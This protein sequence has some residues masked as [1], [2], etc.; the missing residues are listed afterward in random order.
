MEQK[1]EGD[2]IGIVTPR[3]NS[4]VKQVVES[5]TLECH[6]S[7]ENVCSV[8]LAPNSSG[9]IPEIELIKVKP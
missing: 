8:I 6:F 1:K 7:I 9:N 5:R 2:T 4:I 3:H